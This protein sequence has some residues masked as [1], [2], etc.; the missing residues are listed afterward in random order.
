MK[1]KLEVTQT[2]LIHIN[3]NAIK[4]DLAKLLKET[5][6]SFSVWTLDDEKGAAQLLQAG[7]LSIITNRIDM[8]L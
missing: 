6:F 5:G 7:A 3:H 1:E 2:N 8:K 4:D